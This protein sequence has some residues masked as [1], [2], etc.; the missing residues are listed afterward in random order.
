[1]EIRL[2]RKFYSAQIAREARLNRKRKMQS[3]RNAAAAAKKNL[4]T[5]QNGKVTR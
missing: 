4:I 3:K 2:C 5:G 1:M